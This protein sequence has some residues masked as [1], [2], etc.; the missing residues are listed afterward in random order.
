MPIT[1]AYQENYNS[2]GGM[3]K[4]ENFNYPSITLRLPQEITRPQQLTMTT[5]LTDRKTQET[6]YDFMAEQL[7]PAFIVG[8]K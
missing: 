6:I 8:I 5:T 4:R 2:S 1:F 7:F 3:L